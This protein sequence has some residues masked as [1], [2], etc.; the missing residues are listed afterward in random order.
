MRKL[1]QLPI[2][3]IYGIDEELPIIVSQEEEFARVINLFAASS[4]ARGIFVTDH[5]GQFA[6]VI[7]RS[8]LLDWA[9]V[10]V[11]DLFREIS[12]SQD[13]TIRLSNIIHATTVGEI[14][15]PNSVM[16]AVRL[17][18]TAQDA[19]RLMF[20]LDIIVLPV[21]DDANQIIGDIKLSEILVASLKD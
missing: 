13:K 20:K 1:S 21:I 14:M 3:E 4:E 9:R 8:D 15:N 11:G 18:Y 10:Q 17:E 19:L 7:T 5:N 12:Q 6:G 16:A 2:Y